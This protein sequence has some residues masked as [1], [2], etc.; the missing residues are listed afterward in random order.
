MK[1]KIE[2]IQLIDRKG[3]PRI[4]RKITVTSSFVSSTENIWNRLLNVST[5]IEICKPK[6]TFK[7]YDGKTLKKWELQRSYLFKLFVYGFVPLGQ[8]EIVLKRI[9]RESNVILSNEHNKIVRV[10]NHLIKLESVETE[11]TIYTDEVE[12]YAG[13]FTYFVALWSISFY[14]HRQK[15]WRKIVE[16]S[17]KKI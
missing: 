4:G 8:H 6:M 14:K 2:K 16:K 12:L 11:K 7:S 13:I 10:W 3:K 17:N 9:D 15:K 5:L 1:N